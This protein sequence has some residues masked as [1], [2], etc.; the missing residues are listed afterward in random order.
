MQN[1]LPTKTF[2]DRTTTARILALLGGLSLLLFE[3]L[4]YYLGEETGPLWLRA[5]VVSL[6]LGLFLVTQFVEQTRKYAQL[7]V[8]IVAIIATAENIYRM[9]L[10]EF[11]ITHSLPMLIVLAGAS[12]AFNTQRAMSL[13]LLASCLGLTVTMYLTPNAHISPPIY[14]ATVWVLSLLTIIVFGSRVREHA[15][16]QV[17][18]KLLSGIFAGTQGGLILMEKNSVLLANERTLKLLNVQN[19][20]QIISSLFAAICDRDLV[21]ANTDIESLLA[22]GIKQLDLELEVEGKPVWLELH[23]QGLDLDGKYMVIGSLYD[24]TEQRTSIAALTRSELFLEQSQRVGRIGSWD[25]NWNTQEL[26]WSPEMFSIFN[27]P[28]SPDMDISKALQLLDKESEQRCWAELAK[29]NKVG[30]RVDLLVSGVIR[31]EVTSLNLIAE[32]ITLENEPHLVGITQDVTTDLTRQTDLIRAK[33]TAE[34]ALEIRGRFLANMSHEIRTPMNGVIGMTSVLLTSDLNRSQR[35]IVDTI[36]HSGEN[37]LKLINDI[38]DFSKIDAE[39]VDLEELEFS[40]RVLATDT[41]E[42]LR[43]Q[44]ERKNVIL[45]TEIQT[46]LP[47]KLVGDVTRLEQVVINLVGNAIKF[48]EQGSVTLSLS[49]EL[50]DDENYQLFM[51]VK[52]TG[53]GIQPTKIDRLFDAFVQEDA[54]TTRRFGGTG[55]GLAITKGLIDLMQGTISVDSE[56]GVGTEFSVVIPLKASQVNVISV[57]SPTENPETGSLSGALH[58]KLRVLLAEDNLVNQKVAQRMLEK[59]GCTAVVVNNGQEA[60]DSMHEGEFDLILMDVQMPEVDGIA[61]TKSIRAMTDITQPKVI[62]LT[63]NA[64]KAD[65]QAC[66]DAGMDD[67]LPKPITIETLHSKLIEQMT[68]RD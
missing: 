4:Y 26:W 3:C 34:E 2:T 23:L 17:Q 53:I 40:T 36:K 62:A 35:E 60:I 16:L 49:G 54:T 14:I 68:N 30:D 18:E 51:K 22:Q 50:L 9:H 46:S 5:S 27:L 57:T 43:A 55:L 1:D 42:P 39:H 52:D 65:R 21:A 29:I 12:Y 13:F 20:S 47:E 6:C 10:V 37:L 31:G 61:A 38:L 67:Y 48:T 66:L 8:R 64:M 15:Q 25:I 59:L 41:L 56:P 58:S 24:I 44:A 32:V 45:Q 28:E 19:E 63:A 7:G 33:E 11:S